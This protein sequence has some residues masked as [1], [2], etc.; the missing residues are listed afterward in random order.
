MNDLPAD[1][2]INEADIDKM[3]RRL[4]LERPEDT[5]TPEMAIERLEQMHEN[6][7]ELAHTNPE[8]L[9]KWYEA[10]KPDEDAAMQSDH[11]D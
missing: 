1:Y 5:I 4:K 10:V 8:L 6:F 11:L 2:E 9:E 7:H 3:I